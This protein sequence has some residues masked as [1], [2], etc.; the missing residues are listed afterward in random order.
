MKLIEFAIGNYGGLLKFFVNIF[1]YGQ[2]QRFC[3]LSQEFHDEQPIVYAC[4][5]LHTYLYIS[6][7]AF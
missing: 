7:H 2:T 5:Y 4:F 1:R 6:T 3:F